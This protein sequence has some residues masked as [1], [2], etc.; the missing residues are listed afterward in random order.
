MANLLSKSCMPES[1]YRQVAPVAEAPLEALGF[2]LARL[3]AGQ[4]WPIAT[5]GCEWTVVVLSGAVR[6]YVGDGELTA[7]PLG[8]RTSVFDGKASAIYLP[9]GTQGRIEAVTPARL[10]VAQAVS[11]EGADPT[12][13]PPDQVRTKTVGAHNWKREVHD[14]VDERLAAG[15]L[16]VGETFNQAGCW[17][18]YPPHRH[19]EDRPPEEANLEEIY[20]FQVDPPQ[21]FGFQRVYTDNRDLDE[22]YAV[23]HNDVVVLPRGYHPVAA[24]PG[25]RVY[26]LWLL[27]GTGRTM[28]PFDDPQHAWIKGL[29]TV[30]GEMQAE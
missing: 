6:A 16:L 18:S 15:R 14:I 28:C 19:D 24:A 7:G 30:L 1:G 23:E 3:A 9:P 11:D 13:I 2:G 4:A 26:Y 10:A 17:S 27:A 29:E 20:F 25:Y 22:S 21:G 8:S 12:V 5:E